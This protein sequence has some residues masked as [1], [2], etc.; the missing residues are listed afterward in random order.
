[1]KKA[2]AFFAVLLIFSACSK[3]E[4]ESNS[5]TNPPLNELQLFR[6]E[7][8][9]N[10]DALG[11]F[12]I[13]EYT[14]D[15]G[16]RLLTEVQSTSDNSIPPFTYTYG[17][18]NGLVTSREH[19]GAN[20]MG[21]WTYSY[22]NG[23]LTQANV[24]NIEN[25]YNYDSFGRLIAI[26]R[27]EDGA[28]VCTTTNTY[29]NS[30]QPNLTEWDCLE[31]TQEFQYDSQ[32]NPLYYLFHASYSRALL[33]TPNNI[34]GYYEVNVSTDATITTEITYNEENLPTNIKYYADGNY[35]HETNFY[36]E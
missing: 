27:Y 15:S 22:Q 10:D 17:Y 9:V 29:S 33:R 1:M 12:I 6:M 11:H 14:Y 31:R 30:S 32:K 26:E 5:I 2:C 13:T 34:A 23:L 25:N 35:L 20:A 28:L 4:N 8:N 18:T 21:T 19:T 16:G 3:E 24:G 36:Y 7:T